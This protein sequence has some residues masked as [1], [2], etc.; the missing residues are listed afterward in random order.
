MTGPEPEPEDPRRSP[1]GLTW[2]TTLSE[3]E[4]EEEVLDLLC[5]CPILG[6]L[7][8]SE[9]IKSME[10]E[11]KGSQVLMAFL[12]PKIEREEWRLRGTFSLAYSLTN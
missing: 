8:L 1:E 7:F 3:E 10:R 11:T 12:C 6:T 4:E 2:W 9:S 5:L